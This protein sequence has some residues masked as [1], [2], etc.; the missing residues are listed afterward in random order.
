[1]FYEL[2]KISFLYFNW[3]V[4]FSI[5]AISPELVIGVISALKSLLQYKLAKF[6][7]QITKSQHVLPNQAQISKSNKN[8]EIK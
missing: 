8:H 1:M 2:L 3:K 5:N 6:K 7:L 4:V